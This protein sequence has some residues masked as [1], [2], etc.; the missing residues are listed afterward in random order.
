MKFPSLCH[1]RSKQQQL[2]S[3]KQATDALQEEVEL[4]TYLGLS[5]GADVPLR[6]CVMYTT[7]LLRLTWGLVT[8]PKPTF[9]HM[10]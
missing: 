4:H 10:S 7:L 5:I 1:F 2:L 6:G 3:S 8:C 9:A